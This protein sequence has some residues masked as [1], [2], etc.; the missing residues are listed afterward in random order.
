MAVKQSTFSGDLKSERAVNEFLQKYL[1]SR[2]VD[3][4]IIATF[5]S[6]TT[7]DQQHNGID[8]IVYI[9]NADKTVNQNGINI[10]EKTALHYAK[11]NLKDKSLPTFA[12]E[13]SYLKD[14][15]LKIGWLTNEKYAGTKVYFLCWLWIKENANKYALSC[16]DILK[17]EV[18]SIHKK[19]IRDNLIKR[20][21]GR[22]DIKVF[23]KS[24]V[25][26]RNKM[27]NKRVKRLELK[28]KLEPLINAL[29]EV[30]EHENAAQMGIYPEKSNRL[31][32]PQWVL[33]SS[34]ALNEAPLNIVVEKDELVNLA[35]S[36][37]VITPNSFIVK[38][39]VS[40]K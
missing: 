29:D 34:D 16:D 12:F 20:A 28:Q 14:G 39:S 3:K 26:L 18:M 7:D 36:H 38:K 2:L 25:I 19:V 17:I 21:L 30:E 4:G 22:V 40:K 8:T 6:D 11:T 10:D 35:S 32:Y 33:S 24:S 1:Y 37:W 15:K 13:I 31:S 5:N 23:E 9:F 27:S